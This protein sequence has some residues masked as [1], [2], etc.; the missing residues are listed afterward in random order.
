V[1]NAET[2]ESKAVDVVFSSFCWPAPNALVSD[3]TMAEIL[4]PDPM[5]VEVMSELAEDAELAV[6]VEPDVVAGVVV[7]GTVDPV[8]PM[9]E[10]I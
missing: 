7:G 8:V 2:W 1:P 3:E 5:P 4:S 9:I 6:D 10:L